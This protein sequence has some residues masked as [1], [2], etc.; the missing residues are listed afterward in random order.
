[1]IGN[2]V[3][4]L[5]DPDACEGGLHRRFDARVFARAERQRL[6]AT[7][8]RQRLRWMLWAAK[9]AA[10]KLA[11][12]HDAALRFSP[13]SFVVELDPDLGGRVRHGAACYA[14]KVKVAGSCIH[15]LASNAPLGAR[16]GA[17]VRRIA[18]GAPPALARSAVRTLARS[19]LAE[20]LRVDPDAIAITSRDRI[21]HAR[22]DGRHSGIDLSLSHHGRFV[23]CAFELPDAAGVLRA[24]AAPAPGARL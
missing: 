21:P 22:L 5:G 11:R 18:D 16:S 24:G 6:A 15:A 3:V 1:M 14:L 9:E 17:R 20:R 12:K 19:A 13:R 7:G 8:A 2:D 10:F 4:D 23:A